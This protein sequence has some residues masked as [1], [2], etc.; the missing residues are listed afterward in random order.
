MMVLDGER[1]PYLSFGL[2]FVWQDLQ[3]F[4]NDRMVVPIPIKYIAVFI[5]SLRSVCPGPGAV[6]SGDTI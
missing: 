4:F 3:D 2:L 6:G 1:C 5:V